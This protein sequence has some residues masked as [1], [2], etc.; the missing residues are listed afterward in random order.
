MV[1]LCHSYEQLEESWIHLVNAFK[2]SALL[3]ERLDE[4]LGRIEACK[5][6]YLLPLKY[7][8]KELAAAIVG[9][10]SFKQVASMILE[11][12]T[13]EEGPSTMAS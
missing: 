13:V 10:P 1:L 2:S 9:A 11:G 6:K 5:E 4:T 3:E 8:E 12:K 7:A